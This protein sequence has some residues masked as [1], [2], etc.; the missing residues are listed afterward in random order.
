M[1]E[2]NGQFV[3]RILDSID[4][5]IEHYHRSFV[6]KLLMKIRRRSKE[7]YTD[8]MWFILALKIR[9]EGKPWKDLDQYA[10]GPDE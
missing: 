2:T 7:V 9:H 4:T 6:Q 5:H 8:P 3:H 1:S 10:R